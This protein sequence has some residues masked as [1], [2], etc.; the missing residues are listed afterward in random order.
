MKISGGSVIEKNENRSAVNVGDSN[1]FAATKM[2]QH[3]WMDWDGQLTLGNFKWKDFQ[4]IFSHHFQKV[5]LF[6]SFSLSIL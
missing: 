2:F 1:E 6:P 3:R 5:F 4:K